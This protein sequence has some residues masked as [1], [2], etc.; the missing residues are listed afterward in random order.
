MKQTRVLLHYDEGS[1]S[2]SFHFPDFLLQ[3]R[4]DPIDFGQTIRQCSLT[5]SNTLKKH[6]NLIDEIKLIPALPYV[7][8][9]VCYMCVI[10]APF[11]PRHHFG[12]F[13]NLLFIGFIVAGTLPIIHLLGSFICKVLALLLSWRY[14]D[15]LIEMEN[16]CKYIHKGI[17]L[18]TISSIRDIIRLKWAMLIIQRLDDHTIVSKGIP[19]AFQDIIVCNCNDRVVLKL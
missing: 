4:I 14:L 9:F 8:I 19:H 18:Q 16:K 17:R 7:L 15:R 6:G 11:V 5:Y 10:S 1:S 2:F 13:V 3:H 12:T